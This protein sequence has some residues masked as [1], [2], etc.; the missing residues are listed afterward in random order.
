MSTVRDARKI[1]KTLRDSAQ[2]A[3]GSEY[4]KKFIAAAGDIDVAICRN[5]GATK[6]A[7]CG[8]NPACCPRNPNDK[9]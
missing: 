9:V 1:A 6:M 8:G 2:L 3:A 5:C 4:A 7:M